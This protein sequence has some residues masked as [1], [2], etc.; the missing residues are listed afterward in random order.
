MEINKTIKD[1]HKTFHD[2]EHNYKMLKQSSY[3]T[4]G[5]NQYLPLSKNGAALLLKYKFNPYGLPYGLG[6]SSNIFTE[7]EKEQSKTIGNQERYLNER[8]EYWRI[9]RE[10]EAASRVETKKQQQKDPNS[11]TALQ[12]ILMIIV[13]GLIGWLMAEAGNLI[14]LFALFVG[15]LFFKMHKVANM[16]LVF[17]S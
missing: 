17:T 13:G 3:E 11:L 5:Y 6:F 15:A 7:V 14:I 9:I 2:F 1:I 4:N 12:I 8:R 16:G 10:E